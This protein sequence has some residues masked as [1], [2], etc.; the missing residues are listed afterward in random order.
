[1][2]ETE[3]EAVAYVVGLATGLDM[4]TASADYI[5]LYD[6]NRET[7]RAS[8]EAIS[9]TASRILAALNHPN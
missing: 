4:N 5:R 2:L 8:F 1:M 7:L 9:Q 3:A 6:G